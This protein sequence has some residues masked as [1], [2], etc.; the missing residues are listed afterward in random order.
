MNRI[1][2]GLVLTMS[3]FETKLACY[4]QFRNKICA[5][6]SSE[7]TLKCGHRRKRRLQRRKLCLIHV[8]S[9]AGG[10][11]LIVRSGRAIKWVVLPALGFVIVL[12]VVSFVVRIFRF[13]VWRIKKIAVVKFL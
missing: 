6:I 2:P 11:P 9:H 8:Y 10:G 5:W 3:Q 1:A 4:V 13:L 12:V 7:R